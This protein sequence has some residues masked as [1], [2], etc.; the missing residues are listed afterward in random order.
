MIGISTRLF[1]IDGNFLFAAKDIITNDLTNMNVY[2]RISK[3]KTLDGS[4]F[5]DDSGY[6]AGD[7]DIV[8]TVKNPSSSLYSKLRNIFIYHSFAVIAAR[9]GNYLCVPSSIRMVSGNA[10]MSFSTKES[11]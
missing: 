10:V 7:T 2:R 4:V 8:I 6:T 1:D 11:I 5:I 9:E 3:V